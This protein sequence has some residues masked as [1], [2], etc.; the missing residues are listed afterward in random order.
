MIGNNFILDTCFIIDVFENKTNVKK[1]QKHKS[2][3]IPAICIGELYY[4]AF[5]SKL[6]S[7]NIL[8][9]DEF[10]A[11]F[12]TLNIN[13]QTSVFYGKIKSE[14]KKNG[15]PIPENDIWIAALTLQ[16]NSTLVTNDNHFNLISNLSIL[17]Y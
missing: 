2:I 12:P 7:K 11:N 5:L 1:F 9:I 17:S 8:K 16:Y 13:E 3:S 15:T 4:G 10:V 6:P 14:L